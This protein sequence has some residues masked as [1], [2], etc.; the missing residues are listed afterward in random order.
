[1]IAGPRPSTSLIGTTSVISSRSADGQIAQ[2]P[3]PRRITHRDRRHH[4]VDALQP[5]AAEDERHHRRR[6]IDAAG[7]ST[8]GDD[9]LILRLGQHPRQH[10]RSNRVDGSRP[11]L[12]LE[13]LRWLGHLLA[14]EEV[15]GTE[16]AQVVVLLGPTCHCRHRVAERGQQG[17]GDTPDAAGGTRHDHRT[18][19]G[20]AHRQPRVP[21]THSI[22]VEPAVPMPIACTL[23]SPTGRRTSQP[24]FTRWRCE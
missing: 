10:R 8:G 2:Q 7:Q 18:V 21:S 17:D 3:R 20:R 14:T 23:L 22:A 11:C 4:R 5:H 24:D 6:Q 12:G 16:R 15:R 1:M 13:R 9:A 19:A